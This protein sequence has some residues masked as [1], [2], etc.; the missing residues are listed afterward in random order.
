MAKF[1]EKRRTGNVGEDIAAQFL[2]QKG[3]SILARN[4]L[5][6][7]GELD[8]VAEKGGIVHIVEVKSATAREPISRE[9]IGLSQA[10]P[11]ELVTREKLRKVARTAA[12]Y[13]EEARDT[14]EY[15]IDVVGVIMDKE[16]QRAHCRLFEQA[17]EDNI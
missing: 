1:S 3:F 10:M 15:Q 6:T 9:N 4:V 16:T 13:M 14:R 12:L 7:W 2:E 8:I 11:E 17:L 5:R